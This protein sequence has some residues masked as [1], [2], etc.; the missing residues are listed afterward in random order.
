MKK[1]KGLYSKWVIALVI[2]LNTLFAAGVLAVFYKTG[3]EP[4]TLITA[5]FAF[6]VGELMTLAMIRIKKGK[7]E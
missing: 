1:K 2:F 3:S 6:T 7:Q 5:W 4:S